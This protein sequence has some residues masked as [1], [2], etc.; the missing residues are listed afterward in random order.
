MIQRQGLD[1]ANVNVTLLSR[2]FLWRKKHNLLTVLEEDE[3]GQQ[4]GRFFKNF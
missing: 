3:E 1:N 2:R 4:Q